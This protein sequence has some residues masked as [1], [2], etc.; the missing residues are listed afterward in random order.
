MQEFYYELSLK[1]SN[2]KELFLDFINEIYGDAIEERENLLILR[3]ESKFDEIK[4]GIE[5]FAKGLREALGDFETD[6]NTKKCKNIDWIKSY[7][8][9]ISP[10]AVGEFYI[11]PSW[12]EKKD[13]LIDIVIDPS[14]AFGSGH[15]ET[16]SS[17]LK[18]ISKYID[19]D[20]LVLDVGCGSGILSI[21]CNKKGAIVDICD[22]DE[23]AISSSKNN[24]KT[25]NS[26]INLAF[27][28]SASNIDKQYDIVLANIVADVLV[29]ISKDLKNRTKENG[30]L[31]LSGI[32]NIYKDKVLNRFK[33]FQIIETIQDGEWCSLCLKKIKEVDAK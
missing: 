31:I 9:S 7:Q 8:E 19:R 17:C 11:R 32:L 28:G 26:N 5:E 24:F 15:H 3:S 27:V 2:H 1:T 14:L 33:D 30:L 23:L 21:A 22:T 13:N 10:T 18:L 29:F 12:H 16:T 25:N 20:N 6:I 4:W